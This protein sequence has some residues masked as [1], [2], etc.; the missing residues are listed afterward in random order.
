MSSTG[1]TKARRG[2]NQKE[3]KRLDNGKNK[4]TYFNNNSV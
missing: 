2:I 1:S 3:R 4:Q